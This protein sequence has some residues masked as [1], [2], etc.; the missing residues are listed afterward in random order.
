[1]IKV[2]K[3][4]TKQIIQDMSMNEKMRETPLITHILV[5]SVHKHKS[6]CPLLGT[7]IN[8]SSSRGHHANPLTSNISQNLT[9]LHGIFFQWKLGE[10][11]K[12]IP[13]WNW[14]NVCKLV[15]LTFNLHQIK[16]TF[17]H[18][19]DLHIWPVILR[20]FDVNLISFQL[21]LPTGKSTDRNKKVR[22]E[23]K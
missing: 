2:I 13:H 5:V 11:R 12:L 17:L 16:V 21:Q 9:S 6:D 23:I 19:F 7:Y 4:I 18:Q 1:M 3:L 15:C 10:N 20:M 14:C 8:A 22:G